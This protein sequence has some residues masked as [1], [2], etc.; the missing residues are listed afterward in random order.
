MLD[1][2]R[3]S[4]ALL[5]LIT[6][7]AVLSSLFLEKRWWCRHLCQ[8]GGMNGL[9]ARLSITELCA[10]AG[11]CSGTCSSY[12]CFKGSPADGEGLATAGCSLGTH[13]VH[14]QDNRNC[15]PCT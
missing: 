3:L 9:F 12:S 8:I 5:L 2:A 6:E 11:A 13:S 4:S 14:L 15:V 1:S 10:Q 7:G